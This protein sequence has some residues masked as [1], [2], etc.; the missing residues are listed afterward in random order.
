MADDRAPLELAW[1][2]YQQL[3]PQH[4]ATFELW[5]T[6]ETAKAWFEG[7]SEADRTWHLRTRAQFLQQITSMIGPIV[8][9]HD[10]RHGCGPAAVDGLTKRVE[11]GREKA[12]RHRP[13]LTKHRRNAEM[14]ALHLQGKKPLAV[15]DCM[16]GN[17]WHEKDC[18]IPAIRKVISEFESYLRDFLDAGRRR[19]G[20][21]A[22]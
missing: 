16:K 13:S 20:E 17:D 7:L 11:E 19:D 5:R 2:F 22:N 3:S 14:I 9:D 6:A 10:R 15:Q 1:A 4:K 8:E 12:Y 18:T 21:R